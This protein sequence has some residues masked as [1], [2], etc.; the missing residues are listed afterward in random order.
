[1]QLGLSSSLLA[2]LLLLLPLAACNHAIVVELQ[3]GAQEFD[4]ETSSLGLP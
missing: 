1:M 4:L 2:S 3:T